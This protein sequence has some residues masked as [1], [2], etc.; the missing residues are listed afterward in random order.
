MSRNLSKLSGRKGVVD[1]LFAE[2]GKAALADGTP[3]LEELERLADEFLMGKANT[4]GTATFY[5]FMKPENKGKKVYV[6]NGTACLCAGT[7][8]A[9]RSELKNH[10]DDNEI[11]HMTC[12]GRCHENG[13]FHFKGKNYSAKNGQEIASVL[14]AM[15]SQHNRDQYGV[16]ASGKPVLT[17]EFEGFDTHY[18]VLREALKKESSEILEEIKKSGLRGRGGAGFPMGFKLE[19]CRNT[20]GSAKFIICNADEGDPGAYSDRY[21]L[22]QRPHSVLFGMLMAGYVTHANWGI[23]YIRAE[24]PEAVEIV[25]EAI[26]ELRANGLLGKNILG[27]GFDFDLKIIRA[28]GSYI[29]G[30]ETALINSIEGQ[31]PEVRTRPPY[32]AQQ[33]LFNKPTIVNNVE[34]L[35]ALHFILKNGGDVYR[36]LGTEKSSGTKLVCLDSFFKKPGLCEVEMGTPL[37]VVVNDLGGGFKSPVKAMHIGG[38]L[39]GMVPVEKIDD[40]TVD[41]ESFSQWGFLLGHASIVCIPKNFPMIDYLEH[42]FDF[43]AYE[44]CGKCFPCRLGTVRAHELLQKANSNGSDFKID[45]EL[46]DD[47]L[48]TLETGSLCAHGGGIP[49]PVKNALEYFAEELK[50]YFE[51]VTTT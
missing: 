11:G 3:S 1:N 5:D 40:L 51:K 48:H 17:D 50:I 15:D 39:G 6:C 31:R 9:V 35:A 44:S 2:M 37:A 18:S 14:S 49:L 12:L 36:C 22:E 10:F 13:A 24:Y 27:S 25:Q 7:Q 23:L 42:L 47:L 32:P 34:T 19:S 16:R 21:L 4:Y 30:E 33:G 20:E 41:F 45:R 46:F 38:P 28:Q 43:A 26:D 29:C 8:E